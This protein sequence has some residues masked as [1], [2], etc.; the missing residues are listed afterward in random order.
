MSLA[1]EVDAL[2]FWWHSIDLG[3]GIVTPGRKSAKQLTREWAAL[4]L[5]DLRGKTVLDIG[6]WD[7]YFSF[8]A[9]RAGAARVVALDH[10]VW[11]ID[12]EGPALPDDAVPLE[13]TQLWRPD[14]LPGKR[15]FDLA[16]R[17]LGSRVEVV[18]DDF[19]TLDLAQLGE[20]DVVL[21][22]GVVY[23]MR[24]PLLAL[25]RVR[26]LTRELAAIESEA[27]EVDTLADEPWALFVPDR[28]E[29]GDPTNWWIPTRAALVGMC[30]AA[31]FAEVEDLSVR[32][33]PKPP[34]DAPSR[35]GGSASTSPD[36]AVAAAAPIIKQR[37]RAILHA[38]P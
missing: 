18:V 32:R 19:M 27:V 31:E 24:H 12:R 30:R 29:N 7:G 4:Q 22:L 36:S 10:Y 16:H 6:A 23:H 26:R 14:T 37:Y 17:V 33:P 25:E 3:D 15:P 35:S 9:E 21:F 5:P 28:D 13:T 8:A 1:E 2:P 20:F 11:S 38:R 34:A